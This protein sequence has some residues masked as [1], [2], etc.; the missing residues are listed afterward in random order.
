MSSKILYPPAKVN[1]RLEVLSR[2]EDGYH[3]LRM[4]VLPITL[5]DELE[6]EF[7]GRE[8]ELKTSGWEISTSNLVEKAVRYF[9]KK[10]QLDFG[11]KIFLKK[12]IPPGSG[13]GGGSG[14][15]GILL[16]A[17][18]EHFQIPLSGLDLKEIAYQLGADIPFFIFSQPAWVEGIGEKV[19]VIKGFPEVYFLLVKPEFSL[20]SRE[21]YQSYTLTSD[22]TPEP[23]EV[24][25]T[26]LFEKNWEQILK[27]DLEKV[28]FARHPELE[29]LKSA[30]KSLG[31]EG[32]VM[33]GSGPTL[34]G[35][36]SEP[37]RARK[38]EER[39]QETFPGLFQAIAGVYSSG[40]KTQGGF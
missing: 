20:S 15:A 7:T 36:F 27:N 33:S 4:I 8:I 38:A 19:E 40:Q 25:L 13:L 2:Q 35:V 5:F 10:F 29:R 6:L 14:D 18:C 26:R 39:I 22:L 21:V 28:A 11:I 1:L 16:R 34:V 12:N 9:Q 37:A 23:K 32:V 3:Q 31:A 24:I 17:L 30:L